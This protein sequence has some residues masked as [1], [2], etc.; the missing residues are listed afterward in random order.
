GTF[1]PNKTNKNFAPVLVT[2]EA[3]KPGK[4]VD[5]ATINNIKEGIKG[6]RK[7][8]LNNKAKTGAPVPEVLA[9]YTGNAYAGSIPNDNSFAVSKGGKMISVI[10]STIWSYDINTNALIFG[11]SLNAFTLQNI[12]G[13]T[14]SKYDPRVIYDPYKDRFIIVFLNGTIH[15]VSK[16]VVAFSKTN[17]P[18]DGFNVDALNVNPLKNRP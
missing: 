2:Q 5:E 17:N 12:S 15:R 10:N 9:S 4:G 18:A 7:S 1:V 14:Q 3:P 16:I 6:K 13:V 8:K 11:I